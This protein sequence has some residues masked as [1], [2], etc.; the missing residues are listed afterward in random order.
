[1][2]LLATGVCNWD[3]PDILLDMNAEWLTECLKGAVTKTKTKVCLFNNKVTISIK[4]CLKIGCLKKCI[5]HAN[6]FCKGNS[7]FSDY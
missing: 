2:K 1:M 5:I 6:N 3:S 4:P 7:I